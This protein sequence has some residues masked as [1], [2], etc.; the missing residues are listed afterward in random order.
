MSSDGHQKKKFE[1]FKK[2]NTAL[3]NDFQQLNT[4]LAQKEAEMALATCG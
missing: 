3:E 2:I 4:T 1:S